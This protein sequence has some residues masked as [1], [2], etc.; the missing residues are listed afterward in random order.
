MFVDLLKYLNISMS[1]PSSLLPVVCKT[2]GQ[3]FLKR[4]SQCVRSSN[5]FCSSKCAAIHNNSHRK[6]V[7]PK[8]VCLHCQTEFIKGKNSTG[9][10]CCT[11]CSSAHRKD[12]N[13][14]NWL[15]GKLS[16]IQT[17]SRRLSA[18]IR[19]YLIEQVGN[20]CS[21]CGWNQ[22]NPISNK[23]PLEVDH[24]DGNSENCSPENL[25]VLCPNCHSL[26]PT[27]R[28]LNSGKAN[29]KRLKYS[30]LV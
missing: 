21:Q 11:E 27:Y 13:I 6:K 19:N 10:F 25:R 22:V 17:V 4:R 23:C 1:Q 2:C 5:H 14:E 24:I 18:G 30:R 9:K 26:T 15:A 8:M 29:P 20:K 3:N 28:A 16:G 12:I 7:K